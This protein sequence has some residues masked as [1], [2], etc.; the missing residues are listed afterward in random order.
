M[1]CQALGLAHGA[2]ISRAA[3][4][5]HG[6]VSAVEHNGHPLFYNIASGAASRSSPFNFSSWPLYG[7]TDMISGSLG[8]L[9]R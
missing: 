9:L 7:L 2:I 5:V 6:K 1:G 4:P 3:Q 8:S